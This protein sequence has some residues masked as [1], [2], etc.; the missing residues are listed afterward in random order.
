MLMMM[1]I[2]IVVFFLFFPL[3]GLAEGYDLYVSRSGSSG[4]NGSQE[5][6]FK[7]IEKAIKEAKSRPNGSRKIYIKKGTYNEDLTVDDSVELYGDNR[8]TVIA[9]KVRMNNNSLLYGITVSGGRVNITVNGGASVTIDNCAIKNAR[10]I[11]I[12]TLAGGGKLTLKNS[13][14]SNNGT[15]GLYIQDGKILSIIGNTVAGQKEE[16]LDIRAYTAGL[17]SGNSIFGNGEGGIE[18]IAGGANVEIIDNNLKNNKASGIAIQFYSESN[19]LGKIRI[20]NNTFGGNG[21]Y[22]LD[23]VSPSVRHSPAGFYRNSLTLSDNIWQGNALGTISKACHTAEQKKEVVPESKKDEEEAKK[24]K[25][26]EARILEE[27]QK[28]L[29]EEKRM[30]EERIKR[31]Q[32]ELKETLIE[33]DKIEK[34]ISQKARQLI[35]RNKVI[36]FFSGYDR[37]ML[38]DL[39]KNIDLSSEKLEEMKYFNKV[40]VDPEIFQAS[41]ERRERILENQKRF[42][43]ISVNRFNVL[44]WSQKFW[45]LVLGY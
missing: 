45:R 41:L 27:Q 21:K 12:E 14:I 35:T 29:E 2:A 5:K 16:G 28:L 11:G 8:G 44:S 4:G 6:P 26:E 33:Q 20:N 22:G 9:G 37:G 7:D 34:E 15:K 3:T 23:C 13:L 38:A 43:E 42:L 10:T 36:L 31:E 30:E 32:E 19:Q 24:I 1:I 40:A 39:E 25:E 18:I 17:I